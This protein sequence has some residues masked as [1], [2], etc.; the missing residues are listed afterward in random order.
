MD[1]KTRK[2][3]HTIGLYI[4]DDEL[5]SNAREALAHLQ[6][7]AEENAA[8]KAEVER[9]NRECLS[10]FRGKDGMG[11]CDSGCQW[12]A[13]E[14]NVC[15]VSRQG[16]MADLEKAE[17]ECERVKAESEGLKAGVV[18]A[19]PLITRLVIVE[20]KL[21]RWSPLIEA[22]EKMLKAHEPGMMIEAVRVPIT[23]AQANVLSAVQSCREE[24]S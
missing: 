23:Q 13:G 4:A 22:A 1:E 3:L 6:A 5:K 8:F 14:G 11:T 12:Y 18:Q 15:P 19:T 21:A 10:H 7:M 2:A 24:K 20:A 16:L 17:A 9:F